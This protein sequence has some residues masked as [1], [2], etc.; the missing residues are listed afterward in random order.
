MSYE[1]VIL[2]KYIIPMRMKINGIQNKIITFQHCITG[3]KT[4]DRR[5]EY[6]TELF[7]RC[8]LNELIF[9]IYIF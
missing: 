8:Y 4:S 6:Y 3:A 2:L 9:F 7:S 1:N 5:N